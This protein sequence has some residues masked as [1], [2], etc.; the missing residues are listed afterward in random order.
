ML[1]VQKFTCL[2]EWKTLSWQ[3]L[4]LQV[5]TYKKSVQTPSNPMSETDI[6]RKKHLVWGLCRE[7]EKEYRFNIGIPALKIFKQSPS[8]TLFA[9]QELILM[10]R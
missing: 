9:A 5:T 2:L 4:D 1:S 6:Q 8:S 3:S 10:Q 7:S